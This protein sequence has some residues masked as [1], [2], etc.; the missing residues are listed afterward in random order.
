MHI[1]RYPADNSL[2]QLCFTGV[3]AV[4]LACLCAPF[5]RAETLSKLLAAYLCVALYIDPCASG[6]MRLQHRCLWA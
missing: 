4:P 5:E 6:P 3:Q 1:L 2:M